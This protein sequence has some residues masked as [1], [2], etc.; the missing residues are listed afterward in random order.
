M[1]L[2]GIDSGHTEKASALWDFVPH[3]S[4]HGF[5]FG[6]HGGLPSQTSLILDPLDTSLCGVIVKHL[7]VDRRQTVAPCADTRL[8]N[9]KQISLTDDIFNFFIFKIQQHCSTAKAEFSQCLSESKCSKRHFAVIEY[10]AHFAY[11][12]SIISYI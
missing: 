11:N 2:Y 5:A 4:Y 8:L 10:F 1:D 9:L 3:I 6:Y 12:T 7:W